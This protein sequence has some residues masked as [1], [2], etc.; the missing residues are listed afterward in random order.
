MLTDDGVI[1][2]EHDKDVKLPEE[3]GQLH[4]TRTELYGLTGITIY[5]KRGN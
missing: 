3:A 5:R 1:V 4:I 2:C